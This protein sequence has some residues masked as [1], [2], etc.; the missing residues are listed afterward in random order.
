MI[1]RTAV[2]GVTVALYLLGAWPSSAGQ[3][4]GA[5]ATIS[6]SAE[7]GVTVRAVRTL[8]PIKLD[9]RLD[10]SV[11][12][13]VPPFSGFI[14]QEPREGE[15]ATEKTDVWI[16]YDNKNVYVSARC[17]D[18]HPERDVA[19]EM[20]RDSDNIT[21]NESIGVL[22]DTLYDRRNSV[23]FQVALLGGMR[24]G[25]GTDETN[26]NVNWNTVWDARTAHFDH[27]WT[28]E[29]VIPFKSLRYKPGA[30]QTWGVNVRRIVQWKNETS[31]LTRVPAFLGLRGLDRVVARRA[32][33]RHRGD[34]PPDGISKSNR[35]RSGASAPIAMRNRPSRTN[36]TARPASTSKKDHQERHPRPDLQHRL[37]AGRRR[38]P[39]GEPHALQ[40]VLSR[41]PRFLPGGTGHL[42]VRRRLGDCRRD[43]RQP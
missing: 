30:D 19:N 12:A 22:F 10:E 32:D 17:W 25:L 31:Y 6:K 20:R 18:S 39:A 11:Y 16:L 5:P 27:G 40:P 14:Q 8:E 36:A 1:R 41:A 34:R 38:H 28:A 29:M 42:R 43:R 24:D 33:G 35:M 9:G 21:H 23:Y 4:R 13:T 2:A 7:G 15:P 37:R 26:S 3:G